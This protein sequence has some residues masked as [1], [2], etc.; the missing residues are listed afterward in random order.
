MNDAVEASHL[1]AL[2]S[3]NFYGRFGVFFILYPIFR[4]FKPLIWFKFRHYRLRVVLRFLFFGAFSGVI[5]FNGVQK[6]KKLR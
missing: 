4:T 6:L 3:S 1:S 2:I 5:K